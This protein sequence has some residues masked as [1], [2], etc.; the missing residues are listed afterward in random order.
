MA[1]ACRAGRLVALII[2][3]V[4][5][6]PLDVI[7]SGPTVENTSTPGEA[8]AILDHFGGRQ[9]GLAPGIFDFRRRRGTGQLQ[10]TG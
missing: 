9:A 3:D 5:G 6:D 7:A 2:S 10:V 8:L 4:L 1:R